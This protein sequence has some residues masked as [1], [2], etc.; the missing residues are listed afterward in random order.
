MPNINILHA[1]YDVYQ[2]NSAMMD[3]KKIIELTLEEIKEIKASLEISAARLAENTNRQGI[4][5]KL[6]TIRRII[7]KLER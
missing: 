2:N 4:E 6:E 3:A 1:L 7:E 5:N